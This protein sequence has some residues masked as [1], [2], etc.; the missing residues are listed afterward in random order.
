MVNERACSLLDQK[1]SGL[2]GRQ[3]GGLLRGEYQLDTT[4]ETKDP[5]PCYFKRANG[6]EFPVSYEMCKIVV[7]VEMVPQAEGEGSLNVLVMAFSDLTSLLKMQER[8]KYVEQMEAA[9]QVASEIAHEVRSP[10][11]AISGS[12]QLLNKLETESLAGDQDSIALLQEERSTIYENV[13]RETVRLDYIVEKFINAASFSPEA[14]T[15]LLKL[16]RQL[17]PGRAVTPPGHEDP[18]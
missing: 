6:E 1:E 14:V 12:L 2:V 5:S 10:L 16:S 7:P 17:H 15:E 11:T 8:A 4:D 13:I 9:T 18:E 3:I